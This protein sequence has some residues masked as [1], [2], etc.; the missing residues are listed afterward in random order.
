MA[1]Q[2]ITE[3]EVITQKAVNNLQALV[4]EYSKVDGANTRSTNQFLANAG[5]VNAEL[6]KNATQLKVIT[7]EVDK[8]GISFAKFGTQTNSVSL[9]I[10][11]LNKTLTGLRANLAGVE[12]GTQEFTKLASQIAVVEGALR[13]AQA[14]AKSGSGVIGGAGR[15]ASSGFDGLSNS[16]NQLT[17]EIPAFTFSA[18]TGFLALSNNIPILVDN[19]EQLRA[20]NADLIKQGLPVQ[21]VFK[22][23]V[24]SLFSFQTALSVGVALVVLYGKEIGQWASSVFKG[25]DAMSEAK[26]RLDALNAAY[27]SKEL[28]NGVK[29]VIDLRTNIDLAK[30]GI[31]SQEVVLKQ[32]NETLGA[33]SGAVTTLDQ[34]EQGL[35]AN[36]PKY[37]TALVQRAAAQKLSDEAAQT[38]IDIIKQREQVE[39]DALGIASFALNALENQRKSG[40][41]TEQEFIKE[42]DKVLAQTTVEGLKRSKVASAIELQDLEK[43]YDTQLQQILNFSSNSESVLKESSQVGKAAFALLNEEISKTESLIKSNI[44]KGIDSTSSVAELK[45]LKDELERLEINFLRLQSAQDLPSAPDITQTLTPIDPKAIKEDVDDSIKEVGRLNKKVFENAKDSIKANE[46]VGKSFAETE[47]GKTKIAEEEEQNRARL[48]RDIIQGSFSLAS[49]FEQGL[50]DLRRANLNAETNYELEQLEKQRDNRTITEEEFNKKKSEA[51]NK[52]AEAQRQLDLSQIKI[53]TALAVIRAI[54]LSPATFGLPFSAFALAEGA[55]QYAFASAQPLPRFAKGTD[56]VKGGIKGQDSVHA[57]LMPD[58]AV[59]RASEN[60]KHEGM[61]KAWN[62]GNLDGYIMKNFVL[63]A[64]ESNNKRWEQEVKINQ[65]STFIRKDNF[66]DKN[67]VKGLNSINNKLA[68]K[69]RIVYKRNRRLWN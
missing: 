13:N 68:Q 23:I 58:E 12:L 40:F 11:N 20:K 30:R 42:R 26:I 31:I 62:S 35:V 45:R 34:A 66:N 21:S 3:Y 14:V 10:T 5:R 54:A 8:G 27:D 28:K 36:T 18:Q 16:I 38:A 44:L 51:L 47:K 46:E 43:K 37:I 57:L 19:I 64:I 1:E 7:S 9:N 15:S 49:T 25:S 41:I 61:A 2:I 29:G 32:Y 48:R 69:E 59:I 63:P 50:S 67:I 60:L 4:N 53:Q 55:I 24:S 52:Q 39:K 56:R 17:R 22:Q 33:S 65:S 6:A